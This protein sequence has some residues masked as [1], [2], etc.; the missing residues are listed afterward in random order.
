ML[1]TNEQF[2]GHDAMSDFSSDAG[3]QGEASATDDRHHLSGDVIRV[4]NDALA[5]EVR[6]MFRYLRHYF[7]AKTE[8]TDQEKLRWLQPVWDEMIHAE[9]IAQRIR[10]LGGE[11]DFYPDG[12]I[13][14]NIES[15]ETYASMV[16]D[17][18]IE[19]S[20][21]VLNYR[22]MIAYLDGRDPVTQQII[23]GIIADDEKHSV[24][25]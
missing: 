25:L 24:Y 16:N 21:T 17:T 1:S 14:S 11:T 15:G 8:E 10:A 20:I 2:V 18:L 13:G 5:A 12:I 6:C 3:W 23:M 22:R 7:I 9:R 19:E 4:L